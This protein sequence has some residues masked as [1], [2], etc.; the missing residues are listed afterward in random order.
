[1]A[2]SRSRKLAVILHADVVG[3]TTLVRTNETLAHE[4]I[5]DTFHRF[6][7]TI[8]MYGGVARELRGDALVAE[9]GR[10]SD[11]VA[12]SLAFQTEN[13]R[14]NSTLDDDIQPHLRIGVAMGEVVIADNTIT[15]DG[16]VLA[17]RLEQLAESGGVCIQDAAYQTVPK[18]LPFEYENLGEQELKG[19]EEPMRVFAVVLTPGVR[20][21]SPERPGIVGRVGWPILTGAAVAVLVVVGGVVAWWQPWVLREEPASIERM[22][23]PLPDKPSIAVLPFTNMS[24][25]SEQEYFVDGITEDLITDLSKLSGL[26]VIARNSTFTYKNKPVKVRQVAEEL[27]VRFVLEG[28]VRRAGD[29]VRI[30]A[31]LIDATTGGHLWAERYD[32]TLTDV[33]A[34]QDKVTQK[35]VAALAVTITA[36]EGAQRTRKET[37]NP[38]AY[39]AF[40]EGWA[41]YRQYTPED[42]AKAIPHFQRAIQLDPNYGRA[43]AALALV[44]AESWWNEWSVR[45]GIGWNAAIQQANRHLQAA[46]K[47]PTP[48][49]HRIASLMF[50]MENQYEEAITEAERAI[51]LDP[52][53]PSGHD[54]M[55][56]ILL[57]AGKPEKSLEFINTTQRLDPQTNY[58]FRIGQAQFQLEQYEE[59]ATTLRR[60]TQRNAADYQPFLYLASAYGHLGREDEAK[61]AFQ[62]LNKIFLNL[63]GDKRP[64]RLEQLRVLSGKQTT[65]LLR[66]GLH[67]AGIGDTQ[68]EVVEASAKGITLKKTSPE[69]SLQRLYESAS[70]HCRRYGKKSS[71]ISSSS[72]SYVFVCY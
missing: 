20:A 53:D 47:D 38:E 31:Q 58:L 22:A 18:R 2:G 64:W 69:S 65:D 63:R 68:P 55:A 28:S 37:N 12:A 19:F 67:K 23:F 27:G 45:M 1:M 15:G 66:E 9:F 5:Q 51:A 52:N 50:I 72:P 57:F 16:V 26:F 21:P 71:L 11:A 62:T 13:T 32:G 59:A 42:F 41:R 35:I 34:L 33:F 14:F 36:D 48:L 56:R 8:D 39:D 30:N 49:A 60:Y 7:K 3:S 17:Q 70:E 54:A 46:M 10:T 4:R 25:D 29:Q 40:L 6:S 24:G 61:S 43:H 44:Y